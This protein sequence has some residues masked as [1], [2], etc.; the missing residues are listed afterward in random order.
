M[1][2]LP[3]LPRLHA[4]ILA[5]LA[6]ALAS[7]LPAPA[8]AQPTVAALKAAYIYNFTRY[9]EWP[10]EAEAAADFELCLAG[11][12][13]APLFEA[14][15]ELD[16]RNVRSRRIHVRRVDVDSELKGCALMVIEE[17]DGEIAAAILER[18]A[19]QPTLTVSTR[20]HFLDLG[21]MINL[22]SERGQVRFDVHLG[23]ARESKLVMTFQLLKLARRVRQQ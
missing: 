9:V 3:L 17:A 4:C 21:G 12:A 2:G 6:V 15:D 5:C 14:L 13:A 20:D 10:A 7:M 23:A 22:V 1:A 16:G 18:L 19:G 11:H 8:A